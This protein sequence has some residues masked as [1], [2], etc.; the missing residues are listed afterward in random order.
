[1]AGLALGSEPGNAVLL[2]WKWTNIA[3]RGALL[4]GKTP[5]PGKH[6]QSG[7]KV[8]RSPSRAGTLLASRWASPRR[9][10]FV[11]SKLILKKCDS[12][13]ALIKQSCSQS[14]PAH[15]ELQQMHT[16]LI[17]HLLFI[18]SCMDA[19]TIRNIYS[20]APLE[21]SSS[22]KKRTSLLFRKYE[23]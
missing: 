15:Q 22:S 14:D 21:M 7:Q 1:M 19:T 3:L 17:N 11:D 9:Y 8:I 18:E 6:H 2:F 13:K 4:V 12:P 5:K 10:C 23:S 16:E 20:R